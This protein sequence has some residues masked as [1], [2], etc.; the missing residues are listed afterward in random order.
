MSR[1]FQDRNPIAVGLASIAVIGVL[2]GLAFMVGILH[3]GERAYAVSGVFGDASGIRKGD[4]VR[5]AGVKSGRVTGVKAN[6]E[7]GTVIVEFVVNDNVRLGKDASAEIALQTL[8]GTKFLRLS[9]A[10]SGP[11]LHD[12]PEEERVIP[13]ERTKTPFDVFELTKVGTETIQQTDTEK[14][15]QLI[16]SLAD[17]SEGK[18]ED[19]RKLVHGIAEVSEAV[20]AR[21][22]QLR[23]LLDRA[24]RLSALLAEKDDTLV[25]LVD[26]SEGVLQLI[27]RRR[28]DLARALEEGGKATGELARVISANKSQLDAILDTIHP[29]VDILDRRA[30]D[31]DRALSWLGPGAFGLS[32]AVDHGPWQDIYVRSVGPDL[33]GALIDASGGAAP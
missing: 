16:T 31:L 15:N 8:L 29:T 23:Q 7:E 22:A 33:I 24:D 14:L 9:G 6:R 18:Q 1:S 12:M 17:I 25:S 5:V 10:A 19:I 21:D 13:L 32:L 30:A 26:Q 27:A 2:V 3:L 28:A 11:Y 20:S 4:D